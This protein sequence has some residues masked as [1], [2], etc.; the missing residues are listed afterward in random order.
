MPETMEA[1]VLVAPG[2]PLEIREVP[3][4]KAGPGELLVELETC[5]V[6]HSDVHE[7]DD[8]TDRPGLI[9]GHEGV[10]V[11]AA[12]G[13]GAEHVPVGTRVGVPWLHDTCGA[14][15]EC[16]SGFESFCGPSTRSPSTTRTIPR[17]RSRA[18]MTRGCP[19]G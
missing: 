13:P 12:C 3:V 9:L 10:G 19:W 14:C 15:R 17:S 11:A 16:R 2:K 7:R 18:A 4:P 8:E 1:A 6:C 5:G